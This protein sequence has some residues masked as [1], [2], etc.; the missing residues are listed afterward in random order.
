VRPSPPALT[1]PS[2]K[3]GLIEAIRARPRRAV[4]LRDPSPRRNKLRTSRTIQLGSAEWGIQ[5]TSRT[6]RLGA[7][8]AVLTALGID[9]HLGDVAVRRFLESRSVL[10]STTDQVNPLR[11]TTVALK[12]AVSR[13]KRRGPK[14]SIGYVHIRLVHDASACFA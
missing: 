14:G 7:L 13:M 3:R 6:P 12:I 9:A 4:A 8:V 1:P 10:K 5:T 11:L 2:A